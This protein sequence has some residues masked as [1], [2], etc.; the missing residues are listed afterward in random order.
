MDLKDDRRTQ[1]AVLHSVQTPGEAAYKT[2]DD[3]KL[4]FPQLPWRPMITMRHVIV[5][6]YSLIDLDIVVSTVRD[7]LPVLIGLLNDI[8]GEDTQ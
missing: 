6:N 1:L 2:T 4:S 3:Q 5:H 7:D 8:L